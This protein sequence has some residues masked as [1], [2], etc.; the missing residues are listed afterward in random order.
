MSE[1]KSKSSLNAKLATFD[2][3]LKRFGVVTVM[4]AKVYEPIAFETADIKKLKV[5][6]ILDLYAKQENGPL[7][8]L[9]TLKIANITQ[10]GPE[11]TITGGRY[12]NP[13][14]KFGKSCRIEMQDALGNGDAVAALCG[15]IIE[16]FD[17]GQ[18]SLSRV[19]AGTQTALHIGEQFT[20]PKT[21]IGDSFFIDQKT[22]SQVPVTII[23]YQMLPDSLFNFSQDADGDASVF[24][25]NGDLLTTEITIGVNSNT[26]NDII[27]G[28]FYSVVPYVDFA[29]KASAVKYEIT[30][31]NKKAGTVAATC[32]PSAEIKYSFDGQLTWVEAGTTSQ[33]GQTAYV[34]AVKDG[35]IVATTSFVV[36]AAE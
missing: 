35:K 33:Q 16:T 17:L 27:T 14:I 29:A 15:G 19:V 31:T 11:K 24:D 23:I 8:T 28:V 5:H 12:S 6:E 7:C 1:L 13:L 3:M 21:I 25:M 34:A 22:G 10:E 20:G 36:E 9:D 18:P 30:V 26:A 32:S 2:E 4:N